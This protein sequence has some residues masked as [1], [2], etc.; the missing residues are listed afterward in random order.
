M[1]PDS[2]SL[3]LLSNSLY[4]PNVLLS[5]GGSVADTITMS[6]FIV[7]GNDHLKEG[8]RRGGGRRKE[9]REENR[10]GGREG[11]REG[12]EMWWGGNELK[13]VHLSFAITCLPLGSYRWPL[14]ECTQTFSRHQS[15]STQS[16]PHCWHTQL[17]HETSS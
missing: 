9:N 14:Q 8:E 11:G 4:V 15:S 10:K 2:Q 5:V 12:G 13:R 16:P 17:H 3:A 1:K 6:F 7:L